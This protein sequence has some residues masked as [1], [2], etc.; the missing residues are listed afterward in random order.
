MGHCST[1][2]WAIVC[3]GRMVIGRTLSPELNSTNI[4]VLLELRRNCESCSSIVG[5]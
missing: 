5:Y 3:T 1:V 2:L 4:M